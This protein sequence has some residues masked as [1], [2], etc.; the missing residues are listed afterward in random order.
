MNQ[1][2]GNCKVCGEPLRYY[3]A[4]AA[5]RALGA[6]RTCIRDAI[7]KN[8]SRVEGRE[9]QMPNGRMRLGVSLAQIKVIRRFAGMELRAPGEVK[10]RLAFIE[11]TE[12]QKY[13]DKEM[14]IWHQ[15]CI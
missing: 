9:F 10:R 5:S 8:G 1:L 12:S 2:D 7:R 14:Q 13:M 6:Y 11:M 4:T 3:S 15:E